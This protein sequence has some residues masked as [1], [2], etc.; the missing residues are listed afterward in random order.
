M[1]D[2]DAGKLIVIGIVALIV[3]GPKE[4]PGVLRQLGQ[5]IGKM[6]R[7]AGDFQAQ[8]MEAMREADMADVKADVAKLA[9]DAKVDLGLNPIYDLKTQIK[10]AIEEK[11]QTD[12]NLP[13]PLAHGESTIAASGA[14]PVIPVTEALAPLEDTA[15]I[16]GAMEHVSENPKE[17]LAAQSKLA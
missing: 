8:F 3:I 16:G 6:R 10:E 1:F 13:V 11:P 5:A 14:A 12:G 2:F 9:E 15:Q 7:L 17:P 4:L